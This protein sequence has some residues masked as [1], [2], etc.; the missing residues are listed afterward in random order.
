MRKSQI[1][2]YIVCADTDPM[3]AAIDSHEKK[4]TLWFGRQATLFPSRRVALRYIDRTR[5]F[6][7]KNKYVWPWVE[8]ATIMAVR[9]LT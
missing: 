7:E 3:C 4:A 5:V 1:I 9:R 2:G 8:H 6:A